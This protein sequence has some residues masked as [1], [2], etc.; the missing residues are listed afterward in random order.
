MREETRKQCHYRKEHTR[1]YYETIEFYYDI[2]YTTCHE[3]R[4]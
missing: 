3:Q 2:H 4:T 1:H